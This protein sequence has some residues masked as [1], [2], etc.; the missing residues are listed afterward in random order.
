MKNK[1]L[2]T[3]AFIISGIFSPF[4]IIALMLVYASFHYISNLEMIWPKVLIAIVFVIL[5]P[6]ISIYVLFKR[7]I[8]SGWHLNKRADRNIPLIICLVSTLAGFIILQFLH[9]PKNVMAIIA[10]IFFNILILWIITLF[11]KIS[12]H[13][14]TW[15]VAVTILIYMH[16]PQWM[17][18]YLLLIPI[19]WA[20][21]YRKS[22]TFLQGVAGAVLSVVI[23]VIVLS[24][25][26]FSFWTS[27]L[28]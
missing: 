7:K 5:I 20:R 21:I 4:L 16:G 6:M 9:S 1:F 23:S 27:Y 2:N 24:I 19:F 25:Y 11:W 10:L 12:F 28:K 26:G 22:H 8:I 13:A 17:W 14:A 15:T 18:L 3:V